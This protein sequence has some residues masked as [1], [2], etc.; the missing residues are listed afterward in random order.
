M[1]TLTVQSDTTLY[2]IP[3]DIIY[4]CIECLDRRWIWVGEFDDIDM[5]KC[6]FCTPE[7]QDE[8][9]DT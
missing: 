8:D 7:R 5:I 2:K 9:D 6:P 1:K 4:N 3:I